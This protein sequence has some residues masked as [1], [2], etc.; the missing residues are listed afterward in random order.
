MMPGVILAAGDSSRMGRPKAL[1]PVDRSL[2][3]FV[4]QL[5]LTFE[6]GG[7]TDVVVVVGRDE[8]AIG[9]RLSALEPRVRVVRN[10]RH[11]EGQL[12]SLVAALDVV[13]RP[14]VQALMMTLVDMPLVTPE[15]VRALVARHG[16]TRAPVVRP[17][18][19]VRHGHPVIFDRSV[20]D[21]IRHADVSRGAK[22]VV[23]AHAAEIEHVEVDD[24]GAFIDIDTP[25]AYASVIGL[26]LD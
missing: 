23:H 8:A 1:L 24:E 20:F 17:S 18:H 3:T 13:D 9:G 6:T 4:E 7:I 12:T 2:R 15:T 16:A 22:A 10:P 5:I 21:E 26:P 25:E 14:G 19:G 11:A